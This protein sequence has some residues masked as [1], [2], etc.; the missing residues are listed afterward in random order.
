MY[1]A[2]SDSAHFMNTL[3]LLCCLAMLSPCDLA[4]VGASLNFSKPKAGGCGASCETL[5]ACLDR[6]H[7][8]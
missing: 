6:E 3:L 5:I 7:G 1:N 8:S 2:R 4:G